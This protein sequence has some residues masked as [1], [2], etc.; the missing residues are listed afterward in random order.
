MAAAAVDGG[1]RRGL[2]GVGDGATR[3]LVDNRFYKPHRRRARQRARS[4][5]GRRRDRRRSAFCAPSPLLRRSR[6][7]RGMP[8]CAPARR[9]GA[10]ARWRR[11]A[12]GAR[13]A[14]GGRRRHRAAHV[15][16]AAPPPRGDAAQ[17]AADHPARARAA[18]PARP[19]DRGRGRRRVPPRRRRDPRRPADL[20][21]GR[22]PRARARQRAHQPRRQRLQRPRAAAAAC[23]ASRASSS[24]P[25]YF[26]ARTGAGGT[27][28]AHRLPRRPARASRP[29][30]PTRAARPTARGD[31]GLAAV[32][33]P[34][35][36]DFEANEGIADG[37]VLRFLGVPILAAP[38]LSFPLTDE[39]KSG[40]LPPSINLDSKSGF[41]GRACRT[42]G[43]S[44]RTA[45]P[46]SRRGQRAARRRRS[47][48]SSATSSR[49]YSGAV[50]LNLLPDD[51]V[52]GRSRYALRLS[53]RQHRSTATRL[54]QLRVHAR[55]RRRLLEG[56]SARP[57][58]PDAAPAADRP[59]LSARPFGDWTTYARVQRWQVLQTADPATR[60]DAPYERSPQIGAR[61]RRPLGARLRG[62]LRGRVQPLHDARQRRR[63]RT[64]PNGRA[65][66]ALGSI[67]RPFVDA[68]LDA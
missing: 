66:H 42:T 44:R 49:A 31:A 56:L 58:E 20:R 30:P 4:R 63:R 37:A 14:A 1:D 55:L 3:G 25:T 38:V 53:P 59:A 22:R 54:L 67:S 19:R 18:R 13:R 17:D 52:A 34:R 16:G 15:A 61:Y 24:S 40:W 57:A 26:F 33:R 51:R 29:A 43:T 32:G 35:Q 62:R 11:S 6:T 45:M 47:T 60:I 50:D 39:R 9:A 64:R 21:A 12:V 68:G 7:A 65:L 10:A 27:A 5:D 36:L 41:A 48:P 23:S 46:R 2:S 28:R 8:R